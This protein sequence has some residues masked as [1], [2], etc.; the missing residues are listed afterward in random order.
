MHVVGDTLTYHSALFESACVNDYDV[1]G[2]S[3][4]GCLLDE[5]R[6]ARSGEHRNSRPEEPH[7]EADGLDSVIHD[8]IR[9]HGI[10]DLRRVMP[11]K[12]LDQCRI[13]PVHELI[14]YSV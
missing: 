13:R 14:H 11:P 12:L 2:L 7:S 8:P 5:E 3:H 9:R 10:A 6:V 4:I 1:S